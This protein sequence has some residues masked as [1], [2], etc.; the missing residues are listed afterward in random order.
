[1]MA[2]FR[3][4]LASLIASLLCA[5]CVGPVLAAE[6][7]SH[8]PPRSRLPQAA[9]VVSRGDRLMQQTREFA[10]GVSYEDAERAYR[11]ALAMDPRSSDAMLGLAWVKNS[12]H[13]F[14]DGARWA[15]RAL[16]IDPRSERAHA[17]LGDA[18]VELGDYDAAFEHYQR[19]LDLQANLSSYSR[20]A[21][22]L[23]LTGDAKRARVLMQQAIDA[24]SRQH[25]HTAWCRAQLALMLWH[26]GALSDAELQAAE[27]LRLAPRSPHALSV[28]GR[29]K[30]SR[31]E[32]TAAI[33]LY[34]RAT[35]I[36]PSHDTLVAL[37]DLYEAEDRKDLA[38]SQRRR[39]LELHA[40]GK[41]HKH[42]GVVHSHATPE[43]DVQLAR[44]YADHGIELEVALAEA[45]L[46]YLTQRNIYVADTLAWCHYMNGNYRM[47]L[48]RIQEALRYGTPDA[49]LSYHAGMIHARLG[50]RQA[51]RRQLN[52]ALSLNTHFHPHHALVAARMLARLD[53]AV[54]PDLE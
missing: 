12:E 44:F 23:W 10:D 49:T 34:L 52:R 21:Q 1:M 43:G 15:R 41:R 40:E 22:L 28:M 4:V 7:A 35:E 19:G 24:G 14:A 37:V 6:G 29:I 53:A 13:E 48:A 46:A 27:A 45:E 16:E 31:G 38:A 33:D 51:A 3:P 42:G 20:A 2:R 32:Y 47:A 11:D 9:D 5:N 8:D 30:V 36:D 39:V 17:L 54:G 26:E 25:E 18:A 50:D